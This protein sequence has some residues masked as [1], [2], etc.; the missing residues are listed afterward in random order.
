[1]Y[2]CWFFKVFLSIG[3]FWALESTDSRELFFPSD[4]VN[5]KLNARQEH[6]KSSLSDEARQAL[7]NL[8]VK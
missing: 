7:G 2:K 5:L 1:M 6:R 8:S 3:F 4:V